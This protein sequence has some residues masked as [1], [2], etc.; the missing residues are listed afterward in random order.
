MVKRSR[1][2]RVEGTEV[3]P[4]A[5]ERG[6]SPNRAERDVS[7]CGQVF[8]ATFEG[9]GAKSRYKLEYW[10]PFNQRPGIGRRCLCFYVQ[11]RP[12]SSVVFFFLVSLYFFSL[13]FMLSFVVPQYLRSL[14]SCCGC[15]CVSHAGWGLCRAFL[16]LRGTAWS[17]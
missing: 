17:G 8:Q 9:K 13:C 4:K 1:L 3:A 7:V 14:T 6:N 5:S 11:P 10:R 16:F 15:V 12:G 2:L